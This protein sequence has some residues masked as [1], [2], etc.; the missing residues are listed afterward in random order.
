M[1]VRKY[2][3]NV[4]PTKDLYLEYIKNSQDS[5]II[6]KKKNP[7]QPNQKMGKDMNRRFTREDMQKANK[8]RKKC[9]ASLAIGKMEIKIKMRYHY[10][11]LEWLK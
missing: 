10:H 1:P 9:L 5:I 3:Q 11:L 8:Q 2:L 7:K 6:K 4:Y